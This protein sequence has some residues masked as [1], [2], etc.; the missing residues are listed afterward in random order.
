MKLIRVGGGPCTVPTPKPS[1]GCLPIGFLVAVF[2]F[3]LF[4][5]AMAVIRA[6]I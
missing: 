4:G 1:L 5:L 6:W 2:L 3:T